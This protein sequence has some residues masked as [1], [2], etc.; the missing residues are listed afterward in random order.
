MCRSRFHRV[1]LLFIRLKCTEFDFDW[2][3]TVHL[4]S[5]GAHN[6]FHTHRCEAGK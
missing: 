3:S 1:A 2:G 6:A 4:S 5:R